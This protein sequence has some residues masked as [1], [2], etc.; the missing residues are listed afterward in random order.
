MLPCGE[1]EK[2]LARRRADGFIERHLVQQN[3]AQPRLLAIAEKSVETPAPQV[4]INE[5]RLRASLGK[6]E[7]EV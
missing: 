3:A 4:R 7:R 6:R 2:V 1:H 5:Q